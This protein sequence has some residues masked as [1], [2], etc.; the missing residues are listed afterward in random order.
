MTV[1]LFKLIT[2]EDVIANVIEDT[3]T[4]VIVSHPLKI[5]TLS[6]DTLTTPVIGFTPWIPLSITPEIDIDKGDVIACAVADGD[7][8]EIYWNSV[9]RINNQVTETKKSYLTVK[10]E[11]LDI[12]KKIFH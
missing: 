2:G 8:A 4:T 7:L 9:E 11:I 10:D 6:Y 5:M 1:Y 3:E 12:K